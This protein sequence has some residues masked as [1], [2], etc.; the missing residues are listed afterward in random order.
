MSNVQHIIPCNQCPMRRNALKG[1]LGNSTP[2]EFIEQIQSECD[3]PCHCYINYERDD[4]REEQLPFAPSCAG[5]L[6]FMKNQCKLPRNKT[7]VNKV[8]KVECD[9]ENVFSFNHEFLEYHNG[10]YEL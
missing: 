6:V 8:R 1:Y 9:R 2:E 4:W 10:N 7:L 5:V 3:M